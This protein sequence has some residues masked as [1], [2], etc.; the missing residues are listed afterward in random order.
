MLSVFFVYYHLEQVQRYDNP[1][2]SVIFYVIKL[3]AAVHRNVPD[4]SKVKF[5]LINVKKNTCVFIM[6]FNNKLSSIFF[7]NTSNLNVIFTLKIKAKILIFP[8][9]RFNCFITM[10]DKY[11]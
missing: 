7:L 11:K 6:R 1:L 10:F 3:L 8:R 5:T 9:L 4:F 2:C